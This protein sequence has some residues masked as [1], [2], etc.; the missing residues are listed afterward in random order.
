M[1]TLVMNLGNLAVTEYTAPLTG[2]S[3]DF[4]ATAAGV[5]AV[6]G[7][8][9]DGEPIESSFALGMN[10]A[11]GARQQRAE[12]LYVHLTG[13]RRL[14]ATMTSA[15]GKAYTYN[16][17]ERH[18]RVNRFMLGKGLRD[19]Y[20]QLGL[21]NTDTEP[22]VIDQIDLSTVPSTNRRL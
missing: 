16:T 7:S 19:S 9:D 15:A 20:L 2:L 6:S 11:A 8:A 22:F 12:S 13:G 14:K 5:F 21:S 10:L 4:E 17:T 3:G 18:G 1:N